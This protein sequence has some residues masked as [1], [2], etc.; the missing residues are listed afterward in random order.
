MSGDESANELGAAV[1]PVVMGESVTK[2]FFAPNVT[3]AIGAAINFASVLQRVAFSPELV[4]K[5]RSVQLAVGRI[6]L[7]PE[8][9]AVVRASQNFSK[10]VG[11]FAVSEEAK[12]IA[13]ASKSFSNILA[14]F[15]GTPLFEFLSSLEK[16]DVQN[17]VSATSSAQISITANC[18]AR[19][20]PAEAL[21]LE[22]EIVESLRAGSDLENLPVA[23]RNYLLQYLRLFIM[24]FAALATMNGARE[25][26]CFQQ[27][28]W[29]PGMTSNQVGKA[30][31]SALCSF[32]SELLSSLRSVKGQ[33]VRLRTGPSMKAEVIPVDLPDRATLE[34]LDSSN[35]V[36]LKVSVV[37]QDGVEGWISRKYT[38]VI[39]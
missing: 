27:A 7:S 17:L 28:K 25:E 18:E 8:V 5:I 20:V 33:G 10:F 13:A 24:L 12:Q 16:V 15:S 36:W 39:Q 32:P 29:L 23:Q 6:A 19:V 2:Q 21:E 14:E 1:G 22:A 34:V 37:A 3:E 9:G 30:V 11:A 4:D 26:I 35:R 31:R 38:H